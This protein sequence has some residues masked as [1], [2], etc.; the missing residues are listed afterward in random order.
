MKNLF[1]GAAALIAIISHQSAMAAESAKPCLTSSEFQSVA[2][3]LLPVLHNQAVTSCKAFLPANAGLLV[4]SAELTARYAPSAARE[5]A[6][7]GEILARMLADQLPVPMSGSAILPFVEG[8]VPAMLAQGIDAET[9]EVANNL[10]TALAPLPA[11]NIAS[12]LGAILVAASKDKKEDADNE[13]K[14]AS[15]P[16]DDFAVCPYVA[17]AQASGS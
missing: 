7:A 1:A 2:V 17:T 11:E 9:C 3:T 16:L 15:R 6:A 4:Q 10:W 12:T 5:R 13:E 8:M 14:S